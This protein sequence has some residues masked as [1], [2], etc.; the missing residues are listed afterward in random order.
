MKLDHAFVARSLHCAVCDQPKH[1]QGD[2]VCECQPPALNQVDR[3][4][5]VR[6]AGDYY[7]VETKLPPREYF[8]AHAKLRT[9]RDVIRQYYGLV[10]HA[11]GAQVLVGACGTLDTYLANCLSE[12]QRGC[13][14][15]RGYPCPAA[16]VE[17]GLAR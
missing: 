15:R 3:R 11:C 1:K 14:C 6:K 10:Q 9:A 16:R 13:S 12:I 7:L 4:S 5:D 17:V 8:D 2:R